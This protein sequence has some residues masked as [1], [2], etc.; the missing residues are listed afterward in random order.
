MNNRHERAVKYAYYL[1]FK[2]M[3]DLPTKDSLGGINCFVEGVEDL[4]PFI[5]E[6]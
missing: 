4:Q 3:L 2:R 1:Y 6:E 5:Y